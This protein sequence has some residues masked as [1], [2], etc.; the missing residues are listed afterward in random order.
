MTQKTQILNHLQKAPITPL[1]ALK[2][3]GSFRL[4]AIIHD[5][6]NEGHTIFTDNLNVGTKKKPKY[7][8][9]Y[10]LVK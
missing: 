4:A 10:K 9:K 5:L 8:A 6:R 1:E 7:V 3:Y 2:K